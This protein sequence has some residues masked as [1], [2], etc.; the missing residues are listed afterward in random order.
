VAVTSAGPYASLHLAPDRQ[1]CQHPTDND[2]KLLSPPATSQF[3][4]HNSALKIHNKINTEIICKCKI[5]NYPLPHTVTPLSG[6]EEES[7][8]EE[9]RE[10]NGNTIQ[11][12]PLQPSFEGNCFPLALGNG[13]LTYRPIGR[14]RCSKHRILLTSLKIWRQLMYPYFY[15]SI[16]SDV[17]FARKW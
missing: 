16:G 2:R 13:C 8:N 15:F 7:E 5:H 10:G 9:G 1:P 6:I 3:N 14:Y 17:L 12:S 11:V 4:I